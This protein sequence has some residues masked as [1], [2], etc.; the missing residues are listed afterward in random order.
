M[1]PTS[2]AHPIYTDQPDMSSR[3]ACTT[4]H[5]KLCLSC[6]RTS[7]NWIRDGPRVTEQP[8]PDIPV[9][10]RTQRRLS[11][12]LPH[13]RQH[14]R[15][16]KCLETLAIRTARTKLL[17]S[18]VKQ[19]S[20]PRS[21]IEMESGPAWVLV[22]MWTSLSALRGLLKVDGGGQNHNMHS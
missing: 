18:C 19:S 6:K 10:Y 12:E 11:T 13:S 22:L 9:P 15:L 20:R 17:Q 1:A 21:G 8:R 16:A 7:R 14:C 2:T 3:S 4:V 5:A